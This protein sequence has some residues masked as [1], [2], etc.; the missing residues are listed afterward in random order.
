MIDKTDKNEIFISE[1]LWEQDNIR[2]NALKQER[3]SMVIRLG[4]RF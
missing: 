4:K 2:D 1:L 3:N